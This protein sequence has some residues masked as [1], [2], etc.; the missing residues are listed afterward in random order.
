MFEIQTVD[1]VK[2]VHMDTTMST[3]SSSVG[4][5]TMETGGMN[6]STP[7]LDSYD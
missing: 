4:G 3:G 7:L 2:R 5:E 6:P 1:T